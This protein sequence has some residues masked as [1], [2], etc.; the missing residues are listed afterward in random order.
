MPALAWIFDSG[1]LHN[2]PGIVAVVAHSGDDA[3]G[4]L[5]RGVAPH[6]PH[7]PEPVPFHAYSPGRLQR[8]QQLWPLSMHPSPSSF[9]TFHRAI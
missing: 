4:I 2:V 5:V 3:G 7:P 9:Q 6:V 8:L 1:N